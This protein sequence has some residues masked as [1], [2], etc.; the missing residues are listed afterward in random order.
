VIKR[1]ILEMIHLYMQKQGFLDIN[2]MTHRVFGDSLGGSFPQ[3]ITAWRCD[4][5][6]RPWVRLFPVKMLEGFSGHQ[7]KVAAVDSPPFVYKTWVAHL[8]GSD[9][10]KHCGVESLIG[11]EA[12][13]FACDVRWFVGCMKAATLIGGMQGWRGSWRPSPFEAPYCGGEANQIGTFFRTTVDFEAAWDGYEV[14]ILCLLADVLNFT[15]DLR[16]PVLEAG[17]R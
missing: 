10:D 11:K 14:R 8:A 6:S 7:F 4:H 12:T 13:T 3:I 15:L 16:E 2:L 9:S 1:Q 5:F 17:D